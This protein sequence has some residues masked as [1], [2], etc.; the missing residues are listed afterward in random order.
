VGGLVRLE[1]SLESYSHRAK[2]LRLMPDVLAPTLRWMLNTMVK[3]KL[4][5]DR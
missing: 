4:Y 3:E 5:R 1:N 2:T